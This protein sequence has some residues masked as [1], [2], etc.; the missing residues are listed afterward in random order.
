M[1]RRGF[2]IIEL[3]VCTAIISILFVLL[4]PAVQQCR[5]AARRTACKNNL[6]QIGLALRHYEGHHGVLPPGYILQTP[7][8][9]PT[10][11]AGRNGA[12]WGTFILPMLEQSGLHD[13]FDPH[14][15]IDDPRHRKF[16]RTPVRVYECP[17]DPGPWAVD[18]VADADPAKVL[19]TLPRSNYAGVAGLAP[20]PGTARYAENPRPPG[21][22][23]NRVLGPL[24]DNDSV[25]LDE[26]RDGLSNTY[27]IGERRT[28][29]SVG[30]RTVWVGVLP[31]S[32]DAATLVLGT[33]HQMLESG[34]PLP[35]DFGGSHWGAAQ[36]VYADGSVAYVSGRIEPHIYRGQSTI[37]GGE[38]LIPEGW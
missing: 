21:R 30:R 4:L 5:E 31:G 7:A 36:I 6:K 15:G 3:L 27:L 13:L 29:L 16:R 34:T 8:G 35:E 11:G 9:E 14:A 17:S 18:V 2:T 37:A 1:N 24:R 28:D 23:D 38:L 10:V 25:R 20:L 22:P 12:G 26:I 19:A 32:R 33:M